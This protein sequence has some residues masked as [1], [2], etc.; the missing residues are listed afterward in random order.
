M[1]K[2]PELKIKLLAFTRAATAELVKKLETRPAGK[3]L[4]PS[5]VHP[6][7]GSGK[8]ACRDRRTDRDCFFVP[9]ARGRRP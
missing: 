3:R 9:K 4:K 8:P 5:T 2:N 6:I 1:R 7:I